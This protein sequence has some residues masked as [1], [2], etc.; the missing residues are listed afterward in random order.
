MRRGRILAR[1]VAALGPVGRAGP[2]PGTVASAVAVLVGMGLMRVSPRALPVA[3][4]LAVPVGWLAVR[5]AA[6]RGDPGWVVVD[7][8]A[9]QWVAMLGLRQAAVGRAG[10]GG[11]LAAFGLFRLLDIAKPGPVGW[12]DRVEGPVGVMADDVVAGA[13]VACVLRVGARIGW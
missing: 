9:G 6:V 5:G 12:A 3:A 8:L 1:Q 4:V 13:L 7:E 11:A 10:M 2:A